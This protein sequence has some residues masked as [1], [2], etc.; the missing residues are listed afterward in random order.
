VFSSTTALAPTSFTGRGAETPPL[1]LRAISVPS[2]HATLCLDCED[3]FH[4]ADAAS[5]S[6]PSMNQVFPRPGTVKCLPDGDVA[7]NERLARSA[8]R[9]SDR[10]P[11]LPVNR[12]TRP[13]RVEDGAPVNTAAVLL[14]MPPTHAPTYQMF[15]L[16]GTPATDVAR[17]LPADIPIL[18]LS[19][20]VRTDWRL[21]VPATNRSNRQQYCNHS[22]VYRYIRTS[23]T[24]T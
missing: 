18:E 1:L 3:R 11:P 2:A 19:V 20:H 12:S 24:S 16:P 4:T 8:T 22:N 13:A 17:C 15:G 9:C 21:L 10:S 23:H 7:A 6:K 5:F 14:K